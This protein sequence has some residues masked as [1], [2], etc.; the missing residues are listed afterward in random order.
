LHSLKLGASIPPSFFQ[1]P[2]AFIR[3]PDGKRYLVPQYSY[4]QHR[5]DLIGMKFGKSEAD[6]LA[7]E[8]VKK[9]LDR[10]EDACSDYPSFTMVGIMVEVKREGLVLGRA[11]VWGFESDDDT[12]DSAIEDH[13]L[14]DEALEEAKATVERL[15]VGAST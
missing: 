14:I 1:D 13:G 11:S 6:R 4:E 2:L 10:L 3:R 9:D 5:K 7:R 15:C 12:M 8:Y